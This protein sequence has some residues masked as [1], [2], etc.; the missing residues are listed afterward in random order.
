MHWKWKFNENIG[1]QNTFI[2]KQLT[3]AAMSGHEMSSHEI[4][5][6][7][8]FPVKVVKLELVLTRFQVQ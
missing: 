4:N 6:L 5:C 8:I 1:K 3:I 2:M 7:K